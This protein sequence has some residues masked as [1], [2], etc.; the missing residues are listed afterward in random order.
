[1]SEPRRKGAENHSANGAGMA[2]CKGMVDRRI[3]AGAQRQRGEK[4]NRKRDVILRYVEYRFTIIIGSER[5]LLYAVQPVV[6][7]S[8]QNLQL[9][10]PW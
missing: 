7:V 9:L 3:L 2:G 6:D 1:M 4:G 8:F 10:S 5:L